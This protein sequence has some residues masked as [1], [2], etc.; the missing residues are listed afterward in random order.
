MELAT[1]KQ[2]NFLEKLGAI[3]DPENI[4]KREASLLIGRTL[5]ANKEQGTNKETTT[6]KTAKDNEPKQEKTLQQLLMEYNCGTTDECN[7]RFYRGNNAEKLPSYYNGA[8]EWL[9]GIKK[10]ILKEFNIKILASK[11]LATYTPSYTFTLKTTPQEFFKSFDELKAE[12]VSNWEI[13]EIF[14]NYN[15]ALRSVFMNWAP[16]ETIAEILN[17]DD[18]VKLFY[19]W[20]IENIDSEQMLQYMTSRNRCETIRPIY[21]NLI[22]FLSALMTSYNYD[23][24][25]QFMGDCDYVDCSFFYSINWE[26]LH[27]ITRQSKPIGE[28]YK[29]SWRE[30]SKLYGNTICELKNKIYHST[31]AEDLRKNIT[32]YNET[33][34]KF[35]KVGAN[36]E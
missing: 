2:V 35:L 20:T 17:D 36:N 1:V 22:E 31:T 13:L 23:H 12:E 19:N 21:V 32:E 6:K 11:D 9:K 29:K 34:E 26:N 14:Q 16:A 5:K 3:F 4:T 33:K 10:T 7:G 15:E 24:T 8:S 18:T 25:G 28:L 30:Y 27:E